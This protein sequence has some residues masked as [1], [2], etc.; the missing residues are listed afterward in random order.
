MIFV[1]FTD[2]R[3]IV[4][5]S[6]PGA[7]WE[8]SVDFG[9]GALRGSTVFLINFKKIINKFMLKIKKH[10]KFVDDLNLL[11]DPIN[12]KPREKEKKNCFVVA[13][14]KRKRLLWQARIV[15]VD[16]SFY[17]RKAFFAEL[18]SLAVHA[19][20][21]VDVEF[22]PEQSRSWRT[23]VAD[24]EDRTKGGLDRSLEEC[25]KRGG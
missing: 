13:R 17:A 4:R 1:V 25:Y 10:N 2:N 15:E 3:F 9:K 20:E 22:L 8:E 6:V 11:K 14:L 12:G 18:R 16:G 24:A 23:I 19:R 21:K 5:S 7:F